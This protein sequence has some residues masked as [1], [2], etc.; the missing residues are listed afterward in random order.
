MSVSVQLSNEL[1]KNQKTLGREISM[2]R[3]EIHDDGRHR[4]G[5]RGGRLDGR[6]AGDRPV[7]AGGQ[8]AADVELPEVARHSVRRLRDCSPRG[9]RNVRRQIPDTSFAAGEIVPGLQVADAVQNGTVEMGQTA[10][11]YYFGKHPN[12]VFE[13][14]LPLGL[15]QRACYAWYYFG[16]GNQ[17]IQ[18]F[19]KDYNFRSFVFGG[20][21]CQMGGWF[22]KEIKTMDDMKG[23]KFRVGGFAGLILRASR[24]RAAA[25]R[26]RRH[27]SGAGEGH[28]RR[29]PNGSD[30]TTTRSSASTRSRSTTTIPAGGRAPRFGSLYVNNDAWAKLPKLYQSMV[31]TAAGLG[32]LVDGAE[33]RRAAILRRCVAWWPRAPNCARFRGRSSSPA[34]PRPTS[35]MTSCR[36]RIAKF[37]KIYESLKAFRADQNLLLRVAENTFDN[38]NFSMSAAGR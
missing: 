34:S 36:R 23:L 10:A 8:V 13:T 9:R 21:G 17:L 27:L 30:P 28:D 18:E 3:R 19:Y 14:G 2:E 12:F 37:K 24:R 6:R 22:R 4:C 7:D 1:N 32:H 11:Y 33:V 16:G 38:F 25:D 15:N 20:T 5:Q 35:S 26:R 31:E 29:L